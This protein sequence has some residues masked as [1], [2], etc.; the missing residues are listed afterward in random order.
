MPFSDTR[1]LKCPYFKLAAEGRY[2]TYWKQIEKNRKEDPVSTE[3][4]ELLE[5]LFNFD[6]SKR[7]SIE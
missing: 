2:S 1:K 4:K 5:G 3:A 6:P 7:L